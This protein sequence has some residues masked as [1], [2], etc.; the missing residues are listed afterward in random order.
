[1]YYKENK[2][3]NKT[4]II[5]IGIIIGAI[6]LGTIGFLIAT[7]SGKDKGSQNV[8]EAIKPHIEYSLSS[9]EPDQEKIKITIIATTQDQLGIDRIKLPNNGVVT[10]DKTEYIVEENGDYL[11]GVYGK[12]GQYDQV[13]VSIKNIMIRTAD[14]P[15]IPNGFTKV[16][17]EPQN[18]M[19]I[20]DGNGNEF[21]WVPVAS[22]RLIRDK[23]GN[24]SYRDDSVVNNE[25]N[26]SVAKYKGF[27]MGRYEV[28]K[29][30]TP[31]GKETPAI[32]K[33]QT[34]WTNV[35]FLKAKTAAEEMAKVEGYAGVK[36][37]LPTSAAW[38]RA[39]TWIDEV[40][41]QNYASSTDKG[42]YSGTVRK[43]GETETDKMNNIFDLAG[44]VR[45]WT[46]ETY[47]DRTSQ[48]EVTSSS[49]SDNQ[50]GL[51][52]VFYRILR[53]GTAEISNTP[54][55][56]SAQK[57]TEF[58]PLWGFRVVMYRE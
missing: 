39:I 58:D 29:A 28:A 12:N 44:N 32:Q 11:F 54:L 38:Y 13:N 45:E 4:I 22:G 41:K 9:T 30:T 31:D 51:S 17:G 33:G 16:D 26:N 6:I 35:N 36:T 14:K 50:E 53:G 56:V 18:G 49:S 1:M 34:P 55:K 27:Y 43:T 5:I 19:V 23:E 15:Y 3:S 57:E 40:N 20:K 7:S 21:V 37:S 10:G 24:P 47:S 8:V 42:N 25:L 52:N 48:R 2:V 46:T